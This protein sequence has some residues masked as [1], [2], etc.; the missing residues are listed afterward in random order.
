MRIAVCCR[1]ILSMLLVSSWGQMSSIIKKKL[2]HLYKYDLCFHVRYILINMHISLTSQ[3]RMAK[4]LVTFMKIER[5]QGLH[6]K[7]IDQV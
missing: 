7:A 4:K 5:F 1:K 6:R 2:L 3:L